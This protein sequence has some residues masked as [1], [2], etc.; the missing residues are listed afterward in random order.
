MTGT[1]DDSDPVIREARKTVTEIAPNK[2]YKA[3][4]TDFNND[5]ATTFADVQRLFHLA[6]EHIAKRI[7]GP[8]ARQPPSR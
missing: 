5:P 2:N 1:F 6:E 8:S 7:A 3:R 4:L